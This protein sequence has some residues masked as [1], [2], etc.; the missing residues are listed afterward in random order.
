VFEKPFPLH[1][2]TYTMGMT[3]FKVLQMSSTIP[4]MKTMTRIGILS[5]KLEFNFEGETCGMVKNVMF[6]PTH[7]KKR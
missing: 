1:L 3:S 6:T 2:F 4:Y 5:G 7:I